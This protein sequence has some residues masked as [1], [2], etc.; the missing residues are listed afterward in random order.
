MTFFHE[1]LPVRGR[2]AKEPLPPV[3][4]QLQT[5]RHGIDFPCAHSDGIDPP[6]HCQ[7][8]DTLGNVNNLGVGL[9]EAR[10][11]YGRV[12]SDFAAV[13]FLSPRE[14]GYASA[15]EA[16]RWIRE[17]L[18]YDPVGR[19]LNGQREALIGRAVAEA[20]KLYGFVRQHVPRNQAVACEAAKATASIIFHEV[21]MYYEP[22]YRAGM[23][24]YS[25][26]PKCGSP[27]TYLPTGPG[28]RQP[29]GYHC[30]QPFTSNN[31]YP[32]AWPREIGPHVIDHGAPHIHRR[33]TTGKRPG[34]RPRR[35]SLP[36][37]MHRPP[38]QYHTAPPYDVNGPSYIR[39][40]EKCIV[41]P[42][43]TICTPARSLLSPM[44]F[45]VW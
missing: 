31:S 43:P 22:Q 16:Y 33:M 19:K 42:S 29:S 10:F 36:G 14:I 37:P 28:P 25:H 38:P 39:S 4:F 3:L 7:V 5:C 9:C 2:G 44:M 8:Y 27:G 30:G 24:G 34:G 20:R 13:N 26:S 41:M 1:R 6:F 12:Y 11:W 35:H 45:P 21:T 32:P 15:Y 17:S 23:Y 40:P 18:S